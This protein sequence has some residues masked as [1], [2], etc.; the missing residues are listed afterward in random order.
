MVGAFSIPMVR[1]A[2][3]TPDRKTPSSNARLRRKPKRCQ[4]TALQ[5]LRPPPPWDGEVFRRSRLVLGKGDS[6]RQP[7]AR[8]TGPS[9][10][11][12]WTAA[13]RRRFH[14]P[15]LSPSKDLP[16]ACRRGRGATP[17]PYRPSRPNRPVRTQTPH[18]PQAPSVQR[19]APPKAKAVPSHRTPKA[20]PYTLPPIPYRL[21][22]TPCRR[23]PAV[24]PC[25]QAPQSLP[26]QRPKQSEPLTSVI[27]YGGPP[28]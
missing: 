7:P 21:P 11:S 3:T 4:A 15:A 18:V 2:L 23:P 8:P 9:R 17:C 6:P 24:K 26:C 5:R 20:V 25:R 14:L 1:R 10:K 28:N 13:A 12:L 19:P 16:Q 27:K 22:L